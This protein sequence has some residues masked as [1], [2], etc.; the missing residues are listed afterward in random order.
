M[1]ILIEGPDCSGK[2]TLCNQICRAMI[3]NKMNFVYE[4]NDKHTMNDNNILGNILDEWKRLSKRNYNIIVD[5]SVISNHIYQSIFKDG[6][7]V[8][9]EV[10]IKLMN[11][12]DKTIIALPEKSKYFKLFTETKT[13]RHEDYDCMVDV[14]NKYESLVYGEFEFYLLNH[15]KTRIY[16]MF[17]ND[18]YSFVNNIINN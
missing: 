16:D 13:K 11:M 9:K 2:S 14:Y 8:S 12:I 7:L 15:N 3:D 17:N 1:I 10:A 18:L 6:D 5:R 4:H